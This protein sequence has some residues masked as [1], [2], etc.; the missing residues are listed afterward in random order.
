[1][2]SD[3]GHPDVIPELLNRCHSLIQAACAADKFP[4]S[5]KSLTIP[6]F[7]HQLKAAHRVCQLRKHFPRLSPEEPYTA[8]TCIE[9]LNRRCFK[10]LRQPFLDWISSC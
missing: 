4:L 5:S 9:R 7:Y 3:W 10:F 1:M 8:H 2:A 6:E